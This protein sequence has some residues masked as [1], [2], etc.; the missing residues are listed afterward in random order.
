MSTEPQERHIELHRTPP[1]PPSPQSA[2]PREGRA[3][4][5]A[6][7]TLNWGASGISQ[8][9]QPPL[10]GAT[11]GYNLGRADYVGP[12]KLD[13]TWSAPGGLGEPGHSTFA[14]PSSTTPTTEQ[15]ASCSPSSPHTRARISPSAIGMPKQGP[16]TGSGDGTH[17]CTVRTDCARAVLASALAHQPRAA[18]RVSSPTVARSLALDTTSL[19]AAVC[20]ASP[21]GG[22]NPT[23]G[24]TEPTAAGR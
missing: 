4:G 3:S 13:F 6:T 12:S 24:P 1:P 11:R 16:G 5:T 21:G 23:R 9:R 15:R 17:Q 8:P 14:E 20:S 10:N 2:P 18:C 19:G 22:F 7:N